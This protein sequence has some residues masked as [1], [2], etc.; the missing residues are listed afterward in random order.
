MELQKKQPLWTEVGAAKSREMRERGETALPAPVL[1]HD[2]VDVEFPSR[3]A[4]RN[5]PCRFILPDGQ[6]R[7]E[8]P[9]VFLHIHG[10]GWVLMS[11]KA[12]DPFLKRIA[13]ETRLAVLS[14][15]YRLAPEHPFPAGPHDC[16]DVAEYLV[17]HAEKEY[18][19]RVQFVGGES[20]GAYLS[21]DVV[22]HLLRARPS[23][24]FR[25]A[26][27][28]YGCYNLS[29]PFPSRAHFKLP[30]VLTTEIIESYL[31]AFVPNLT[32][33]QRADPAISPFWHPIFHLDQASQE[34]RGTE[35]LPPALFTCGTLDPLLDDSI[36]MATRWQMAGA[37]GILKLFRGM[38]HGFNMFPE[39]DFPDSD[40]AQRIQIEF[41]K[42]MIL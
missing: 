40:E 9:G 36:F 30:L 23:F 13:N 10:G 39:K 19:S 12:Q 6:K 11:H 4:G 8:Q 25:G 37:L 24:R 21:A 22:L 26:I 28:T 17:D 2:A 27:L 14:V 38:P 15:G 5:I 20:A 31:D 32:P 35:G 7:G 16:Q 29:S 41:M 34:G 18:G 42:S 33:E 3:D 1:L